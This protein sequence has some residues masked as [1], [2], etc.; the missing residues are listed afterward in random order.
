[1]PVYSWVAETQRGRI[2][3][4]EMEAAD[5][6]IVRA[7]LRRRRL[8]L[9]KIKEKPKD[10]SEYVPFLQPKVKTK[11]VVVFTRQFS[12]MVEA[13]LPVVQGLSILAD[14]TENITFKKIL[15]QIIDDVEKEGKSLGEALSKHPDVF[16]RLYVSLVSAGEA[17]GTLEVVL[18]RL[19]EYLE[20]LEKIKSKVKGALTYPAV[21]IAIAIIVVAIIMTFVIP[22]FEKM[23]SEAGMALPLP[24]Q[25]VIRMSHF[26]KSHIHYMI[27]M[28]AALFFVFKQIRRTKKGRYITDALALRLPVFGE[29]I[30]KSCIARFTRTFS[31]MVKSGVPILEALDIVSKTAGNSV[32]EEAILDVKSGIAEGFS[33]AE[34]LLEHPIF[35]PMVV[36]MIA[37]GEATG[38][39]DKMLSKIAEFYEQEVDATVEALSSMIEPILI[40][41][42]GGTIGG[43]VI[44][45]YLP[46]FQMAAVFAS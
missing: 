41:F 15:K 32:I 36:Q 22:V 17:G 11:D 30:K 24:T 38:E 42:L 29:L 19:A 25:M 21:V 27:A 18:Q 28:T 1:M 4:G 6:R 7:Q 40:V 26:V 16:D 2:I 37:V 45:M 33:I 31:T 46:I 9:I 34:L 12:T 13:G 43:L 39:L 8:R 35:P 10:L 3:K 5:E 23:F 44:S 14:Q 20:K